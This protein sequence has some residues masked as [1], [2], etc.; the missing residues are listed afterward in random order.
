[1]RSFLDAILAFIGQ[2]SLSDAEFGV[3]QSQIENVSDDLLNYQ[4]LDS[5]LESRDLV[6]SA[7]DRLRF[8]YL[9]KGLNI[10]APDMAKSNIYLGSAL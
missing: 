7:R 1:M 9:S 8:Y 6:S 4:A 3:V 2:A 10:P 5:V